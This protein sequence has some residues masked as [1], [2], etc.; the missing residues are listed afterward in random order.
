VVPVSGWIYSNYSG[1][2]VVYLGKIPLPNLVSKDKALANSWHGVHEVLATT[3]AIVIALHVLAALQ[4]HFVHKDNTLR[5][6]FQWR[7]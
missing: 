4:H 3:L 5:R 2:P 7:H 6:M 1:Y